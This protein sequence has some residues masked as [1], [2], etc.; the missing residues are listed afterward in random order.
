MS[1]LASTG[2]QDSNTTTLADW[3]AASQFMTGKSIGNPCE[4]SDKKLGISVDCF[5]YLYNASGCNERGTYNPNI[6]KNSTYVIPDPIKTTKNI[7]DVRDFYARTKQTA[8]NPAL[9]NA[10]RKD[11]FLACYGVD[12][13]QI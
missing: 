10:R 13:K 11:A 4:T 1:V 5:N 3:D 7:S 6:A 2:T 8:D 9:S 12:L